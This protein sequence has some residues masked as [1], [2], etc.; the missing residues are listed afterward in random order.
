MTT[1]AIVPPPQTAHPPIL[2]SSLSESL[3]IMVYGPTRIRASNTMA[4][5]TSP[6]H[7]LDYEHYIDYQLARAQGRIKS[8]DVGA[9]VVRLITA[10]LV[11]LLIV[12]VLDHTVVL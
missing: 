6:D 7:A 12:I 9:A 3:S 4:T 11:Y 1:R 5:T 10:A 8:V 2:C